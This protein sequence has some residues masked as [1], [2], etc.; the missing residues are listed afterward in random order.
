MQRHVSLGAQPAIGIRMVSKLEHRSEYLQLLSAV[1]RIVR[2][3]WA[4]P[5]CLAVSSSRLLAS[6]RLF[7]PPQTLI[8]PFAIPIL[9]RLSIILL[10]SL[11]PFMLCSSP[12]LGRLLCDVHFTATN[13]PDKILFLRRRRRLI[14]PSPEAGLR[15]RN[16]ATI[17]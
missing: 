9:L 6:W 3:A 15:G 5:R 17:P 7:Q 4:S 14:L 13:N 12:H 8:A 11:G 2:K 10:H 1:R 16:I